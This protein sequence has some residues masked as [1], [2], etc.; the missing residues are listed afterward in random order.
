[1]LTRGCENEHSY[2]VYRIEG[3]HSPGAVT[4]TSSR[5]S[6]GPNHPSDLFDEAPDSPMSEPGAIPMAT[7]TNRAGTNRLLRH[8]RGTPIP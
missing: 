7:E 6:L 8:S 4:P 2:T 3:V 5:L 1:M